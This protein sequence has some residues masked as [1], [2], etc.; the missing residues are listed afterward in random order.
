MLS[1]GLNRTCSTIRKS[2]VS[3]KS[4][5]RAFPCS[6]C[7]QGRVLGCT[8]LQPPQLSAPAGGVPAAPPNAVSLKRAGREHIT[9][10][11]LHQLEVYFDHTVFTHSVNWKLEDLKS[12]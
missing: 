9:R 10:R 5:F 11:S 3:I 12:K 4:V 6:T 1:A 8:R 7:C 2:T